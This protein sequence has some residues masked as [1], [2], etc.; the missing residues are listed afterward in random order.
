M[1]APW[2]RPTSLPARARMYVIR[3]VVYLVLGVPAAM[4]LSLDYLP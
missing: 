4:L 1:S 2:Y 3:G